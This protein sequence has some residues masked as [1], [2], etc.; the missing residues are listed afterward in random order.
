M[1][2]K[3]LKVCICFWFIEYALFR[4]ATDQNN[5]LFLDNGTVNETTED[6]TS[7]D[8]LIQPVKQND[9]QTASNYF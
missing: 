8:I 7:T 5:V 2:M 9:V 3:I 1:K 6:P 4:V